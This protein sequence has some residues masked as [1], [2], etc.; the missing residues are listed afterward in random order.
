MVA[1]LPGYL[2]QGLVV[3][4]EGAEGFVATVQ[5]LRRLTEEVVTKRIVHGV[6]SGIVTYLLSRAAQMV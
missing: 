5:R 3:H 4:E 1:V 2:R 6:T